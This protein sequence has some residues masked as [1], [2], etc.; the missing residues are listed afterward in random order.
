MKGNAASQWT[1][2]VSWTTKKI[3]P[4]VVALH[5]AGLEFVEDMELGYSYEYSVSHVFDNE[6]EAENWA[7]S[8]AH[9]LLSECREHFKSLKFSVS[10]G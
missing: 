4:V 7:E 10:E 2:F 9:V 5:E 1:A 3:F 8:V 6:P